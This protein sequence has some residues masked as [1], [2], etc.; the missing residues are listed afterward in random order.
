MQILDNELTLLANHQ[1][2][3]FTYDVDNAYLK[4]DFLL[5]ERV[6]RN[7]AQNAIEITPKQRSVS[8]VGKIIDSRLFRIDII[9]QGP[10]IPEDMM[11]KIFQPF[12]TYQNKGTGLGL[13]IA[14]QISENLSLNMQVETGSSGTKF[15]LDIPIS[16]NL[17]NTQA[18]ATK[19]PVDIKIWALDDDSFSLSALTSLL[20]SWH[21]DAHA[22]HTPDDLP[23]LV[24]STPA[25]DIFIVDFHL[26]EFLNAKALVD[27]YQEFFAQTQIIVVSAEQNVREQV[28]VPFL[29]KPIHP[30]KLKKLIFRSLKR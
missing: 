28:E 5:V 29:L 19:Q 14:Q 30:A 8:L 4:T 20:D 1:G 26:S 21:I 9:D 25:P 3:N 6:I 23:A 2:V 16:Q 24:A 13:T 22:V 11:E 7:L 10:G 12:I 27:T 15:S 18:A 17:P